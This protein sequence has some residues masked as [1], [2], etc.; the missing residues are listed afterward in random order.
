MKYHSDGSLPTHGEV[1]VFGSNLAGIHGKG[2]ALAA[3]KFG[4][5]WGTGC[6]LSGRTYAI[7][8]KDSH[9]R[10]LRFDQ[11]RRYIHGFLDYA[12]EHPE[13]EF[14]VTRIGCGLARFQ[15]RLIAHVT[16]V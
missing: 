12:R 7:P 4:A 13:Q 2:A 6:G 8:T 3:L 16:Y 15:D 14:F 1:F 10:P 9:L 5:R 11:V